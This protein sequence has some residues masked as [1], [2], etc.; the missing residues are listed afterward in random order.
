MSNSL[1]QTM[2]RILNF[3]FFR[4]L[5]DKISPDFFTA[6]RLAF[7]PL[8]LWLL[9]LHFFG[10]A[11]VAFAAAAIFD[12]LDGSLYRLRKKSSGWG[13]ILDPVADKLLIILSC[14]L[15][16]LYYPFAIVLILSVLADLMIIF[17]AF[18]LMLVFEDFRLPHADIFGK[19]KMFLESVGVAFV[20]GYLVFGSF[21]LWP[22]FVMMFAAM[23]L[24]FASFLAYGINFARGK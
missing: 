18:L 21:W 4:F 14:L 10:W 6:L 17:S 15:L 1:R 23:L 2:D 5:P 24:G 9:A 12:I 3:F 16:S 7:I 8:V 13:I 20:F 11:L 19:V 22:S